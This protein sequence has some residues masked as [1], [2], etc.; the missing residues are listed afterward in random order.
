MGYLSR[1]RGSRL[2]SQEYINNLHWNGLWWRLY[3][4]MD[5]LHWLKYQHC[6]EPG[7]FLHHF[8]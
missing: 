4:H 7:V 1:G 6:R 3:F 5:K 8:L 2:V